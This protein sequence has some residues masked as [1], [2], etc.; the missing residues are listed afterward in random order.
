[1]L[2]RFLLASLTLGIVCLPPRAAHAQ[3]PIDQIFTYSGTDQH[4]GT[5]QSFVVPDGVSTLVVRLWGA[6]GA[7]SFG[8]GD[9][10][11]GAFVSGTLLVT[12][13]GA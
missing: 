5:L 13:N 10:G 11:G 8:V 4:N 2:T 7:N 12:P 3:N 6:G 1:M 9:G